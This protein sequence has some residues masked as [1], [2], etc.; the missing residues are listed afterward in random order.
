MNGKLQSF[1]KIYNK[2]QVYE[3]K[4]LPNNFFLKEKNSFCSCDM[5][6]VKKTNRFTS[7]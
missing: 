3:S 5:I 6:S 1:E 2:L 7:L 4:A